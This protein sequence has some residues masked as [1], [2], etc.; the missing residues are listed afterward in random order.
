MQGIL[1]RQALQ[2]KPVYNRFR[3]V[4]LSHETNRGCSLF[5]FRPPTTSLFEFFGGIAIEIRGRAEPT[6]G[7][8]AGAAFGGEVSGRRLRVRGV[9]VVPHHGSFLIYN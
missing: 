7:E 9:T 4:P 2:R 3:C 5:I 1:G 8:L 6:R